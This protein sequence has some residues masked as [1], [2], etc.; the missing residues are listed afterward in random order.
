[1]AYRFPSALFIEKVNNQGHGLLLRKH[2]KKCLTK[3]FIIAARE[4]REA[5][6]SELRCSQQVSMWTVE[7]FR[8][9]QHELVQ[10][11]VEEAASKTQKKTSV[12]PKKKR[13]V[14][15]VRYGTRFDAPC[16]TLLSRMSTRWF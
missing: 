3:D 4:R 6:E 7:Q 15:K 10:K 14:D 11:K 8:I 9:Y 12:S 2:T 5:E 1:M 13:K 16:H